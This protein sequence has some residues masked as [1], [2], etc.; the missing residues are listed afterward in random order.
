MLAKL[1]HQGEGFPVDDGG[2]RV[3]EDLPFLRRTL[4][5]LFVLEGLS[6]AAEVYCI[7]AVLLLAE[8]IRHGGRT[9]VVGH[10][11]RLAAIPADIAPMLGRCRHL[12][13]LQPFGDLRRTE[14]VHTP[15][16]NLPHDLCRSFIH[17]PPVLALRVFQIPVGR[18]GGQR[19]AGH[20]LALEHIAY[21]LAG[22]LSVPLIE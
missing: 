3:L 19:C 20:S 9:P 7:A 2:M 8:Y 4:D 6:G 1:L 17:H 18:V 13:S 22:V 21:L 11:G 5:F 15:S 16:E 12:G 14:A 10:S